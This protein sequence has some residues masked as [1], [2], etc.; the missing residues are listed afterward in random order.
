MQARELKCKYSNLT[1]T[2]AVGPSRSL[3]TINLHLVSVSFVMS[4]RK[5]F[6]NLSERQKKRRIEKLDITD[7]ERVVSSELARLQNIPLNR[8]LSINNPPTNSSITDEMDVQAHALSDNDDDYYQNPAPSN[9]SDNESVPSHPSSHD[10]SPAQ[11]QDDAESDQERSVQDSDSES[12]YVSSDESDDDGADQFDLK[13]FLREWSL[14]NNITLCATSSLLSGL[15]Q[16]GHTELPKDARTLL[17]TPASVEIIPMGNGSYAH[18]GLCK[19]LVEQLHC[20]PQRFIPRTIHFDVHVDGVTVSKSSKSELFT[21]LGCVNNCELLKECFIIG[22]HH[23]DSKPEDAD[24]YLRPLLEELEDLQT[25]GFIYK[26]VHYQIHLDK[27]VADTPARNFILKFPPHNSRCGRC[28]QDGFTLGRR[29]LFLNHDAPPRTAQN[30]REG[31]PEK[32][33]DSSQLE[34]AVDP[35]YQVPLEPMHQ[36]HLG[37]G[38]KHMTFFISTLKS[39]G[40]DELLKELNQ[41]Y[42]SLKKWTPMEFGRKPRSFKDFVHFKAEE[43]RTLDLYTASI[44]FSKYMNEVSMK[45]FNKFS[46]A[47]RYLTSEE[48]CYTKNADAKA[49]L[50]EYVVELIFLYGV[51]NIIYNAHNN[52]HLPDEVMRHGPLDSFSAWRY[53][54]HLRFV[55]KNIRKGNQVLAQVIKRSNEQAVV[56]LSRSKGKIQELINYPQGFRILE[57]L[58]NV[59]PP[60]GFWAPRKL[61][62][63]QNFTLTNSKPNNCCYLNDGTLV[64]ID[65]I[66]RRIGT[67]DDVILFKKFTD[68]LPIDN[69]PID[70]REVGICRSNTL[71]ENVFE[72]PIGEAFIM[73][74]SNQMNRFPHPQGNK[75]IIPPRLV[76]L[77]PTGRMVSHVPSPS[78]TSSSRPLMVV[79]SGSKTQQGALGSSRVQIVPHVRSPSMLSSPIPLLAANGSKTQGAPGPSRVQSVSYVQSPSLLSSPIPLLA[80]NGGKTLGAPKSPRVQLVSHVQSPLL[81]SSAIPLQAASGSKTQR[82][83]GSSTNQVS[84]LLAATKSNLQKSTEQGAAKR[85]RTKEGKDSKPNKKPKINTVPNAKVV[86]DEAILKKVADS[87]ALAKKN[88]AT[89]RGTKGGQKGPEKC[90]QPVLVHQPQTSVMWQQVH[91]QGIPCPSTDSSTV[92]NEQQNNGITTLTIMNNRVVQEG[93]NQDINVSSQMMTMNQFQTILNQHSQNGL[94]DLGAFVNHQTPKETGAT[95]K[96]SENYDAPN[97][98]DDSAQSLQHDD[99]KLV[100]P[101]ISPINSPSRSPLPSQDI[102]NVDDGPALN[103]IDFLSQDTGEVDD[104]LALNNI[105]IQTPKEDLYAGLSVTDDNE[106]SGNV[107]QVPESLTHSEPASIAQHPP[108]EISQVSEALR[109]VQRNLKEVEKELHGDYCCRLCCTKLDLALSKLNTIM[110]ILTAGQKNPVFQMPAEE[111]SLLPKFPLK[112]TD[113]L[114]E[115]DAILGGTKEQG[116]DPVPPPNP[117]EV[118]SQFIAYL[119]WG[120]CGGTIDVVVNRMFRKVMTNVCSDHCTWIQNRGKKLLLADFH[121]VQVMTAMIL[122]MNFQEPPTTDAISESMQEWVRRSSDRL[123]QDAKNALK[124]SS[125][126]PK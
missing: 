45:H 122:G 27:V 117:E 72:C 31:V 25:N 33:E 99:T 124:K 116:E 119:S 3:L 89:T 114:I 64:V 61:I 97:D 36:V 58:K 62:K 94:L 91:D 13:S 93:N 54:N 73:N 100:T 85:T 43:F 112:T 22:A 104:D 123:K 111:Y 92:T 115:F 107:N 8:G 102:E 46:L 39:L 44:V 98:D 4:L 10:D 77:S 106:Q 51:H 103:D 105:G 24:E 82:V 1:Q 120:L 81:P 78:L 14:T 108:I 74:P 69:Y 21:I 87:K 80:A 86:V 76:L 5:E 48:Y 126:Q 41:D 29:C 35:I 65:F 40:S 67:A 37:Q 88:K 84:N 17:K 121:F 55:R 75:Q 96:V 125:Q 95:G 59:D 90:I 50:K 15:I 53:E 118:Q 11:S 71:S 26:D 9:D 79:A 109:N 12:N 18:Y 52:L 16:A 2:L 19:A 101:D 66:C 34:E 30:L 63:F 113:E 70:S 23:G 7:R 68:C 110:A 32:Y 20:I 38:K 60:Q 49:L 28:I 6:H 57:E 83:P 42:E 47:I 56:A